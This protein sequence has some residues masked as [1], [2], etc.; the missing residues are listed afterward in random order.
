MQHITFIFEDTL[1]VGM[2]TDHET[3]GGQWQLLIVDTPTGQEW[4]VSWRDHQLAAVMAVALQGDDAS[5]ANWKVAEA[6]TQGL[7]KEARIIP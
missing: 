2:R 3:D 7:P 6:A 1:V 4:S 5:A